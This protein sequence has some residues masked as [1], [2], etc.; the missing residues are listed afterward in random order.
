MNKELL[1]NAVM[2]RNPR[3]ILNKTECYALYETGLFGNKAMTWNSYGE[4]LRSG[5]EGR[6][7][8]RSKKGIARKEVK[9]NIKLEDVPLH[10]EQFQ[11][12]GIPEDLI[13]FNQSMPDGNLILQGEVMNYQGGIYLFGTTLKKPMN[14]ALAEKS[15]TIENDTAK[16]LLESKL[17]AESY[18]DLRNLLDI[19]P[20]SVVEFSAYSIPVGNFAETGRN[21]VFWEV[22][23][24]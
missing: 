2:S 21:T 4:I 14:I 7:C 11:K 1:I 18:R 17:S 5:W 16:P 15:F 9:Y 19:F 24:Y 22:R 12:I 8:M 6:V 10:I 23:N 3:K 20:E 13:S